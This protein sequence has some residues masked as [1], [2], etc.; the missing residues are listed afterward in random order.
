M[1]RALTA[2]AV[3]CAF[4]AVIALGMWWPHTVG[5]L[6][7]WREARHLRNTVALLYTTDTRGFLE[8]CG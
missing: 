1:A 4:P 2:R 6:R 3:F 5:S 7:Q 8:G